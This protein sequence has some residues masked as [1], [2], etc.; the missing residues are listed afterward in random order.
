M[1]IDPPLP[2]EITESIAIGNVKSVAE[3]SSMLSNLAFS[4]LIANVNLSQQNAVANQQAVNQL[5]VTVLGKTVNL[6]ANLGPLEAV[7]AN[8]VLTGNAV[9]EELIDIIGAGQVKPA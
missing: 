2:E 3:Q 6:V 9:A 1:P 7:S 5:G 8:Q 4:N